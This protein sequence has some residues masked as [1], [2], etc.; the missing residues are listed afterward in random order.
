[1]DRK[2]LT[3]AALV[4]IATV[5]GCASRG[6]PGGSRRFVGVVEQV[7]PI[8]RIDEP[9]ETPWAFRW[10]TSVAYPASDAP[11]QLKM[12][13]VR[14]ADNRIITA[15]LNEAWPI[16]ACVE[17]IPER[18]AMGGSAFLYNFAYVRPSNECVVKVPAAPK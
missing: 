15:E 2:A 18:G 7:L 17:V 3:I 1:M 8:F 14:T 11:L 4:T 16:G 5:S 13:I 10:L 6:D 12:N 9:S